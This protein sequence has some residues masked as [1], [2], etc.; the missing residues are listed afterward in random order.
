[1]KQESGKQQIQLS[2]L[3]SRSRVL[4]FKEISVWFNYCGWSPYLNLLSSNIYDIFVFSLGPLCNRSLSQLF[5][6][7]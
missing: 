6:L 1:M 4:C 5:L 2:H 7:I 3:F